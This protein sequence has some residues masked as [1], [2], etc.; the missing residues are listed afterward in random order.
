MTINVPLLGT[1]P[2]QRSLLWESG[3]NY[4]VSSYLFRRHNSL[5]NRGMGLKF[6]HTSIFIET[7][8]LEGLP[9]KTKEDPSP[10]EIRLSSAGHQ[11]C[12]SE[13]RGI[14]L[15]LL[16]II[17]RA[18]LLVAPVDSVREESNLLSTVSQ[19]LPQ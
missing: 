13:S 1:P 2:G 7:P 15:L 12:I 4:V 16:I 14:L 3:S 6:S 18:L 8:S 5:I 19:R 11:L 10:H 17:L 9:T